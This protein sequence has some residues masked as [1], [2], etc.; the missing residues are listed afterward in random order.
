MPINKVVQEFQ[1]FIPSPEHSI[2]HAFRTL[3]QANQCMSLI[4][5]MCH[6]NAPF[7]NP[8]DDE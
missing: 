8:Q 6:F 1:L 5:D 2:K 7:P 3:F 4:A